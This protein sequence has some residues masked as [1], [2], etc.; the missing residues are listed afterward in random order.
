MSL[1]AIHHYYNEVER[2]IRFGGTRKETA[3]R[4]AFIT[5]LNE[6]A[7]SKELM[8]VTEVSIR[9]PKGKT[10]SPDGTLKDA[11]RQ[12]W[13]YYESKDEDDDLDEE[14]ENKFKK[15]YPKDNILFEDSINAVLF[16]AGVEVMR[17]KV[18][19]DKALDKML[20]AFTN[21]ERPEVKQFR[22]AIEL[23]KQDVPKVTDTIKGIIQSQEKT[24][25]KFIEAQDEFIEL[26][27]ESI[28]P[29]ISKTDIQEMMIQHILTADIFNT[30]FDE[31]HFHRENNIAKELEKVIDTF[32]TGSTRRLTLDTIKH[33]YQAINAAGSSIADHHE[34][35]RFLKVIYETFYKS[36][37]PKAADRLGVVYT[38]NE[39]V[40]FMIESTDYLL[41]KH[42]GK[43]LH[44]KGVEILDPATGTG[45]FVCDIIDYIHPN[46][47]EYKYKNEIHANEI[48][49]LPYYIA[50]LNI[51]FTYKQ[52]MGKY[53][54]Y[55]NLCFVDT[56]DNV[57]FSFKGKQ[58]GMFGVSAENALR[59]K[60][61]NERKI[62]VVIG[63]PPYNAKQENYN[64]Q[65]SNKAYKIVDER[66]K[67]TYIKHGTAQNQIVV[68]D[69]YTRFF[70]W[71]TDRL[72]NDGVVC[73]ITNNSYLNGR[74]FDGFRKSIQSEFQYAYF[75]DLGGNIREL[76]GRDGIFLNEKHT[77]FGQAA[78]VGISIAFL[79]K[80]EKSNDKPCQIFYI[81]PTDIRATREEKINF[82]QNTKFADI[83]FINTQPDKKNNWINLSDNDF[84]DLIPLIDKSAKTNKG[85]QALFK[86]YSSGLKTQRDEW[87]YDYDKNNL[88]DKV[89]FLIDTYSS[90]LKDKK[91]KDKF[92]IKWDRELSKYLERGITKKFDKNEIIKACYR[93]FTSKWF[94]FDKHFNGMTYQWPEI[95]SEKNKYITIPGLSSPKDFHC[96]SYNSITDL[97]CLPAGCQNIP[98]Y[99]VKEDGV[100][101]NLT[102]WGL[103]QFQTH[104]K[105]KKIT[106]E[107]IFNYCYAIMHNPTYRKK[108]ELNL[109]RD[110]PRIP[111]Y[112]SFD[113]WA[114][115]GKQLMDLHINYETIKPFKLKEVTDKDIK[116]PKVKLKADKEVGTI[117]IDDATDLSG[118]PNNAWLYKLGNRSAIEW[119]LDQYKEYKPTDETISEKFNTYKFAD[120]KN[121]VIDLLMRVTTV[122]V[123]TM[124]II[125]EMEK[126]NK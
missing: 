9:T 117:T 35:Q 40:K 75:I 81:H 53:V 65:N 31:P 103:E 7:R 22:Q 20:K 55:E 8:L 108:Y 126:E 54:E 77:I 30:I 68:Y 100:F 43:M 66:I 29:E 17:I 69:M 42:F 4:T 38:P 51:E 37:N 111:F 123:E 33:Y 19:D 47:L 89:K 110:F 67:N 122:S 125:S 28:N 97:N 113:K 94:Y 107:D 79:V 44:D 105:N 60:K 16:Q 87:V 21:Y 56:L 114:K 109:K 5:L 106:K 78:A 85:V 61:Q 83:D 121:Q 3:V 90:T 34:K 71:A 73:M 82:L 76:S 74:A 101:D 45:T 12:D 1:P 93:P 96:I 49:I 118:I 14:I 62:S 18:E 91:F 41:Q 25:K 64:Y 39:I 92:K 27:R 24:N 112:K 80:R 98:L 36:Y 15:G 70:R 104:Y 58:T 52:K 124:A 84:E 119:V 59:I 99:I 10:I 63:N 2:I 32:F 95:Y 50:N 48:A 120:Y 6:Y 57:G 11:M 46:K 72:N 86:N 23:F 26:C 115:W 88:S 102:D 13:G 116:K